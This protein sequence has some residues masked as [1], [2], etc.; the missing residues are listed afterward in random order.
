MVLVETLRAQQG[1]GDAGG[2]FYELHRKY[3]FRDRLSSISLLSEPTKEIP[4]VIS[5][6]QTRSLD[7]YCSYV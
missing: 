6:V 2:D 7:H 4:Q 5:V 3:K 1:V